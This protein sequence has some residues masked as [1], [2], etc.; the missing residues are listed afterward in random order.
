MPPCETQDTLPRRNLELKAQLTHAAEAPGRAAQLATDTLPGEKQTDTYFH[1]RSGR[2]KLREI[3][4]AEG[5]PRAQLIA[6]S[7]PDRPDCRESRYRL[8]PVSDPAELKQALA[9]T[10]G[11]LVVVEKRRQIFLHH[12]VRIHLDLVAGLGEFIEFEA[13]M[14][15]QDEPADSRRLLDE[16]QRHFQIAAADL[17]ATSYSDLLIGRSSAAAAARSD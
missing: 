2:L 3:E 8:A 17:V 12:N 9:E 4:R 1:V 14:G 7:R 11:V 10:L 5:T 16:L 15:P 6:Y 13:V